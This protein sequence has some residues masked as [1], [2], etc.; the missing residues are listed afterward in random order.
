MELIEHALDPVRMLSDVLDEQNAAFDAWKVRC[1][2][3]VRQHRQVA[4]PQR[5]LGGE[6]RRAFEGELDGV[7]GTRE[8]APAVVERERRGRL[9]AKVVRR[10]R[11]AGDRLEDRERGHADAEQQRQRL[12]EATQDVAVH[13]R[14]STTVRSPSCTSPRCSR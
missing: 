5:A 14:L 7:L 13:Y 2:D 12:Q 1:S 4:A 3:Q 11:S 8:Q 9:G 10:E 6:L